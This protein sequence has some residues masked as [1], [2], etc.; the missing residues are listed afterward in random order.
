MNLHEQEEEEASHA[1][2]LMDDEAAVPLADCHFFKPCKATELSITP[3]RAISNAPPY[4]AS[5]LGRGV[6]TR[7]LVT[8]GH[9]KGP[10]FSRFHFFPT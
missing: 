10:T 2:W 1:G 4:Q 3:L 6:F 7:L 8:T 9:T 5:M